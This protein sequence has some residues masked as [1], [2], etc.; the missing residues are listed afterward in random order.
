MKPTLMLLCLAV[1]LVQ[2]KPLNAQSVSPAGHY[3]KKSGGLGEM[4]VEKTPEGWRIFVS[5]GGIPNRGATAAD[6]SLIAVGAV[7]GNAFQGEI[8]YSL[9]PSDAKPGPD[10]AVE[11]GHKMTISFAPQSASVTYAEVGSICGE[12]TGIFGRYT[13]DRKP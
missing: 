1:A 3:T 4:R 9:D 12:R 2:T 13:K 11:S 5:A 7:N 6:C 10:N 8:K